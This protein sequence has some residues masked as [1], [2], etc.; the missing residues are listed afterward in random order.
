MIHDVVSLRIERNGPCDSSPW[1]RR[2]QVADQP[3][4]IAAADV[5]LGKTLPPVLVLCDFTWK[6]NTTV[7]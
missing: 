7:L 1:N 5:P 2:I 6:K 3:F 4:L